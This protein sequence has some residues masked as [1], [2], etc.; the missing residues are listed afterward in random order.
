MR[1]AHQQPQRLV[2]VKGTA[3][4]ALGQAFGVLEPAHAADLV[5][6][7]LD[8]QQ[9]PQRRRGLEAVGQGGGSQRAAQGLDHQAARLLA[10]AWQVVRRAVLH[11]QFNDGQRFLGGRSR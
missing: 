8:E 5:R 9:L 2:L 6:T 1:G 7:V 4:A 10:D 11:M 3:E